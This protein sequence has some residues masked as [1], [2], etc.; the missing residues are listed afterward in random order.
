MAGGLALAVDAFLADRVAARRI[1]A[2]GLAV[3]A[4][5]VATAGARAAGTVVTTILPLG[6]T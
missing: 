5:R 4:A 1:V 3:G 2:A 6:A